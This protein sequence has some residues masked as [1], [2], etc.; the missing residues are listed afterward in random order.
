ML[1]SASPMPRNP[2][3]TDPPP[4][5]KPARPWPS[6][7]NS[8]AASPPRRLLQGVEI[9]GQDDDRVSR[10][11]PFSARQAIHAAQPLTKACQQLIARP[12]NLLARGD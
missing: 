1:I 3:S 6:A 12:D 7:P 5:A 8:L 4:P 11:Q 9:R 2:A 10:P